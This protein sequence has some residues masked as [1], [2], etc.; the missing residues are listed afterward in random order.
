MERKE[1]E[2][3]R[4]ALESLATVS[5]ASVYY[6]NGGR[7]YEWDDAY[8]PDE[9]AQFEVEIRGGTDEVIQPDI[10]AI[11]AEHRIGLVNS[12]VEPGVVRTR[13]TSNV[14]LT[15]HIWEF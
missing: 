9:H 13:S 12:L 7:T 3:L 10:L 2:D 15:R 1:A 11:L 5:N 4:D 6:V 14:G 8:A